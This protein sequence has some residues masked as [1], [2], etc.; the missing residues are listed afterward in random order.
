M[1][2]ARVRA[3]R[4]A[5]GALKRASAGADRLVAPPR[6]AVVLI[7]HRVGRRSTLEVDL[8]AALFEQQIAAL[9]GTGRA[10]T[11]D[12]ALQALQGPPPEHGLDPVVVTFD[13]GTADFLDVA[14]PVLVEHKVPA[15]LYV[16]TDFIDS[17]REFPDR[18]TPLSWAGVADAV[19]SGLVTIGSHT[20]THALF[21]RLAPPAVDEELDRSRALIAEH[22]GV[23]ATHFAYP[24][25][26]AGSPAADRA[27][28]ARFRSA[29]IAG[30]RPNPYGVTDP[31]R[32]QRSP[33][34]LGDGMHWFERKLA[35][36]M[37]MEDDVRRLANR[38]RYV[39]ATS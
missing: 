20:H 5:Q 39:G 38:A 22:L 37:R 28:R 9:A 1:V 11:L 14:L 30:T 31:Y 16:A 8:P 36:G 24:K 32:L 25:A 23:E 27:V 3:R 2:A 19:A 35:G 12:E 18:G 21:D 13:D 7:Y 33:V 17:G 29:A 15:L 10:A 34:Q 6:G 4:L 26:L